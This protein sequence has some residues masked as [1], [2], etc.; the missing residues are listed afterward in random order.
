MIYRILLVC[1]A[2]ISC[3]S[4]GFAQDAKSFE[5]KADSSR[6]EAAADSTVR[7]VMLAA[8]S[9]PKPAQIKMEFKP[10]PKKAV[11]MALVPG[12]G[13][14]YNRK[15]WKIPIVY[16]GFLGCLYALTWNNQMYADYSQAY[17]DIMDDDPN[18]K[19]YMNMLPINYDI[20]GREDQYKEI[21]KNKKNY[22][23]KYRDMSIFAMIGVYLLSVV[24]AYVDAE[25]SSFD[26]SKD[27]SLRLQPAVFKTGGN[28]SGASA[29]IQF[30]FTLK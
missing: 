4:W 22:Y 5:I 13:Q 9:L 27:L 16:G 7:S 25:L 15:L 26:I 18:T 12:L 17:L 24:D 1:L 6:I 8:D 10:D 28:L 19:S 11:L 14:I 29:G 3:S 21:F 23:R 30:N 20:T 2:F